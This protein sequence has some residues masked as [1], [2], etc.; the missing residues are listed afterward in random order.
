VSIFCLSLGLLVVVVVSVH[1]CWNVTFARTYLLA[2]IDVCPLALG[3]LCLFLCCAVVNLTNRLKLNI[4]N[5]QNVN[6]CESEH[7][8]TQWYFCWSLVIM[9]ATRSHGNAENSTLHGIETS[10]VIEIK[11]CTASYVQEVTLSAKCHADPSTG[12]FSAN[13]WNSSQVFIYW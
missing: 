10:N 6:A 1:V 11:F 8:C 13:M 4:L 9:A 2:Q 12:G 5:W 3:C 7:F